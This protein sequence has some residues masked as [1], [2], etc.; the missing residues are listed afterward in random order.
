ML[1]RVVL[2]VHCGGE[3]V[4]RNGKTSNGKQRLL[5]KRTSREDR[6]GPRYSEEEK[7]RILRAYMERPSMRGIGRI[8]GV[9]RQTLTGWLKKRP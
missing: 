4:V 7:K 6:V 2:C 3:D 5:C 9:S 8:F 1:T